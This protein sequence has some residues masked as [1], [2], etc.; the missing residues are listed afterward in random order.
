MHSCLFTMRVCTNSGNCTDCNS[1]RPITLVEYGDHKFNAG[2]D[3]I[4]EA[5]SYISVLCCVQCSWQVFVIYYC[6]D[7]DF[8]H[9]AQRETEQ[10]LAEFKRRVPSSCRHALELSS[11]E[12]VMLM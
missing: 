2:I 12:L 7:P 6:D 5:C 1:C 3:I 11:V 10:L 4:D 8:N 9:S